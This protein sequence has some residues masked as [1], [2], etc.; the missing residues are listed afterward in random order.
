MHFTLGSQYFFYINDMIVTEDV[1]HNNFVKQQLQQCFEI[2]DFSH[3][4]IFQ[5]LRL[6]M[7]VVEIISLN[8]SIP[9][10]LFLGHAWRAI[11]FQPLSNFIRSF[12]PLMV[13]RFM[14][15]LA[16]F[17]SLA[18]WSTSPSPGNGIAYTVHVAT[19]STS[20]LHYS[21]NSQI[22]CYFWSTLWLALHLPTSSVNLYA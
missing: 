11:I 19:L 1:F 6:C 3:S 4:A 9:L 2:K 14:K 17:S 5:V 21:I 7:I 8:L 13:R 18:T 12:F 20:L 22:L 16:I 15:S 10:I